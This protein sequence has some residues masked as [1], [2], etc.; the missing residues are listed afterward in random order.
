[1]PTVLMENHF[2]LLIETPE[3]NLSRGMRRL[4]GCYTQRFNWRHHRVG[5]VLQGRFKSLVVER[6]RYLLE[7]CRYL[8]LNPVRAGL[9]ATPQQWSWSSYGATVG[10][11]PAPS[12]LASAKVLSLFNSNPARAQAAYRQFVAG[13][14]GGLRRGQRLPDRYSWAALP[15]ENG[16]LHWSHRQNSPMFHAPKLI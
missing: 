10:E 15:F 16:W 1:M 8:V 3:P 11:R 5:H 14:I 13:G 2:H 4:N 12:W 9:V 6:A 7:L